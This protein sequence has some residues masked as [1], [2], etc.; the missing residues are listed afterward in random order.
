MGEDR[1]ATLA[2]VRPW[3][4]SDAEL[5]A[6]V[7][8]VQTLAVE[9]Q[10]TLVRFV[11]EI[12]VRRTAAEHSATSAAVWLRNRHLVSIRSA[13]KL[14]RLAKRIDAAPSVVGEAVADGRVNLDQA[15]VVTRAVFRIPSSVGVDIRER[16]AAELVRLCG[17]LD[18]ELLKQVGDRILSLVAPEVAD[19]L[20]RRR[21]NATRRR[22]AK[23]GTSP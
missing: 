14:V 13:H 19:E 5:V 8:V 7:D 15:D 21:P 6:G 1:L 10:A 12:D 16:A 17:E 4:L 2:A 22:H 20:D 11:R 23:S 9:V 3:A 18:P